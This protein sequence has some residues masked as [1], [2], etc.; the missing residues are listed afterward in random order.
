MPGLDET[1]EP[2]YEEIEASEGP[3]L[4]EF[5]ATWCPHCQ[6]MAPELFRILQE[7]PRV[8]HIRIEDGPGRRLGRA[9]RV[10]LWPNLVFLRDGKVLKQVARPLI[11]EVRE[12][13]EAITG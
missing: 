13:F 7:Y 5:G 10:K 6:A 1:Q 4:L 2:T 11:S 8:R 12:G 9:F 3:L